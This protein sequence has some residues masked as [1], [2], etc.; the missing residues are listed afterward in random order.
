MRI[1]FVLFFFTR[2]YSFGASPEQALVAYVFIDRTK[3]NLLAYMNIVS[4]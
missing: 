2:L 1:V 4:V 3:S